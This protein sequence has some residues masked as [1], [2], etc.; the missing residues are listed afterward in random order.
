MTQAGQQLVNI[1]SAP[2]PFTLFI[3]SVASSIIVRS[4]VISILKHF[5]SPSCFMAVTILP[6]TF[7]P[8]GRPN[9]SPS[10]AR[11]EGAVKNTTFLV[12][13]TIAPHTSATADFSYSAP[14]GQATMHWPQFTQGV[15]ARDTS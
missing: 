11:T 6:S 4:A 5:T 14:T 1:G 2:P 3:S 10:V 15:N 9:A 13:S 12:S 7:V 8:T